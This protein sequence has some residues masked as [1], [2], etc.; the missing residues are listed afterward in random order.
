MEIV[1]LKTFQAIKAGVETTYIDVESHSQMS[2]TLDGQLIIV[3]WPGGTVI[4]SIANVCWMVPKDQDGVTK[5]QVNEGHVARS[6]P[7]SSGRAK[8]KKSGKTKVG[9]L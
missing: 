4:T 3:R 8:P 5:E 2:I 9:K 7:P 6:S 1:K